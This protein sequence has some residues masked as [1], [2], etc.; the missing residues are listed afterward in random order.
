MI[1]LEIYHENKLYDL[2]IFVIK[3]YNEQ[4]HVYGFQPYKQGW[5]FSFSQASMYKK[6][7]KQRK[8][9]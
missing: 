4:G 1:E 5:L 7:E 8:E 2:I 6:N 3:N 9:F